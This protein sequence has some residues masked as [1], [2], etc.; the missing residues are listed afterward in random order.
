MRGKTANPW[1]VKHLAVGRKQSNVILTRRLTL[2]PLRMQDARDFYA[3]GKDPEVARYVL[4]DPHTSLRQT[5]SILR[6]LMLDSRIDNLHTKAIVINQD[7]SM[8]G[9]I[10]LV[11]QDTQNQCAEVGFSL[12]RPQWGQGLM[13]EALTAYIRYI[14]EATAINRLDAVHDSL[15]PASG[16]VMLKAGM[17]REG[18]HRGRIYYKGRYATVVLY[19]ILRKDLEE[20]SSKR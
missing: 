18:L 5:R 15:N 12:A 7:Q 17:R 6:G 14:F 11:N 8:V 9:T 2:R 4:W 3:Y 13:T 19:A 20:A 1:Y 10:G 16:S